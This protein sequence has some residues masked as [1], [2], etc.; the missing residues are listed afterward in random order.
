MS[1]T[2]DQLQFWYCIKHHAVEMPGSM[3]PVIDRLGP[4]ATADEA[5]NA[6]AKAQ[7]RNQEW[8]SDPNWD[9]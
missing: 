7:Q 1:G 2:D 9:D 4:Y 3:C 6:L 5:A 8:D